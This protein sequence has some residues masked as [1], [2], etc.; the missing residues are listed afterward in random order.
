MTDLK[1]ILIAGEGGQGIQTIAKL[2][3]ETAHRSGKKIV[4]LPNF[5]VE[6]RGGVSLAFIQTAANKTISFPKFK[7]AD[8][9]I[10]LAPRAID[11]IKDYITQ[12]S[13]IIFD[14]SLIEERR[15]GQFSAEKVAIPATLIAKEKLSPRA[16]NMIIFGALFAEIGGNEKLAKTTIEEF[17]KEKAG[18]KP[19]LK[20]LN[21][22]GFELGLKTAGQLKRG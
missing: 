11:R 14:N 2:F 7:K 3:V 4:Y 20:H 1:R 17:F 19:E 12:E 8:I 5:G 18:K 16:F 6:Q 22:R 15:M 21:L 9:V 10:V 13:I